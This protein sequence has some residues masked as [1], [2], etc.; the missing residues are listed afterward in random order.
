MGI[1]QTFR[2]LTTSRADIEAMIELLI[3]R[4]DDMDGDSEAESCDT[5]D[6][7]ALSHI[8]LCVSARF[9]GCQFADGTE[10]DDPAEDEDDDECLAGDDGCRQILRNGS[11]YFGEAANELLAVCPVYGLDQSEGPL[12]EKL[13]RHQA[14]WRR[15]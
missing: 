13:A 9:P 4:L 10:D 12:N 2:A 8:A 11:L 5:E 1:H 14:Q 15:A 6:D 3:A 7:F